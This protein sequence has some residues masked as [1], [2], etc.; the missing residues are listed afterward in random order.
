MVLKEL[1]KG[2]TIKQ[3]KCDGVDV[4][5]LSHN[6]WQAKEGDL[7][8]CIKG[9]SVEGSLFAQQA[10]DKGVVCLVVEK[11][12]PIDFPQVIVSDC[13]KAMAVAAANFYGNCHRKMN[14]ISVTGTNGKTTTTYI[15]KSILEEAGY[16]VAVVG[17]NGA[18]IDNKHLEVDL[19]TPDQIALHHL[20]QQAY[21]MG[22]QY[23][24]MEIS[25]HAIALRKVFGIFSR[26]GIFTN[27][28]NEHL[29]FFGDMETYAATKVNY[30]NEDTM[31]EC[32]V[33]VDDNYG[34]EIARQCGIPCVTYGLNNPANVF[35]VDVRSNMRG[36][37][38]FVNLMD[39]VFEVNTPLLG[40]V[41]VYNILGAITACKMI[42]V[43]TDTIVQ[44]LSKMERVDGRFNLLPIGD[45]RFVMIDFAHTP[46]GFE[47]VLSFVR[48][49]INGK[50]VTLFGCVGYSDDE[51][52]K[53]MA[54]I[55]EK[56]SDYVIVTTD[57]PGKVKF[58]DI[59]SVVESGFSDGFKNYT[60]IEDRK[61]AVAFGLDK[62]HAGDILL[63]L[64]K[65]AEVSQNIGGIKLHY[66]D[67]ET[68]EELLEEKRK[69]GKI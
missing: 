37:D 41:N 49:K 10:I 5:G 68:V 64:G 60:L 30:F 53:E 18:I 45:N 20:F 50:V 6:D 51:K 39:E 55:A 59:A 43:E 47:K 12:L 54:A 48:N 24:I 13:R 27:I 31:E 28:S 3:Y 66:N 26:V 8:F 32:V 17:T 21:N 14:I 46:D 65:G 61:Q 38:F 23:V 19:T 9:V 44:A 42:G 67:R 1:F 62:I 35:A 7:F 58:Y 57:N 34:Q 52:R 36:L 25:A 69:E 29:D 63:L 11:K 40:E 4:L 33:N 56:Y 2:L 16:K 22:V 15:V